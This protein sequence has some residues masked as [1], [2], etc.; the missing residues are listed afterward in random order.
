[1]PTLD[2]LAGIYDPAKKNRHGY[3]ITGLIEISA[4]CPWPSDTVGSQAA[5]F[6]F[7]YGGRYW[8]PQSCSFNS[9]ALP[10]RDDK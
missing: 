7:S 9:R 10:V 4:C 8:L 1:M 6:S 3:L 5:V 2:E